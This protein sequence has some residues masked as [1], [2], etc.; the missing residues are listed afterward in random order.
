MLQNE[1][2]E[3]CTQ[4]SRVTRVRPTTSC[5]KHT[6]VC[7]QIHQIRAAPKGRNVTRIRPTGSCCKYT[8]VCCRVLKLRV[9]PRTNGYKGL[10]DHRLL[11]AHTCV[12][13]NKST[14]SCTEGQGLRRLADQVL[15]G[16]CTCVWQNKRTQGC[17]Q[18]TKVAKVWPTSRP[19]AAVGTNMCM[20]DMSS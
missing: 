4:G 14:Q 10:A 8:H 12:L 1:S 5:C 13:Q 18:A 2:L 7:C 6:H 19:V 9:R 11:L 20:S 17:T 16:A 15:L 3:G